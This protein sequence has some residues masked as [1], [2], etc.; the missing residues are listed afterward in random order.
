MS[1]SLCY[2]LHISSVTSA[3]QRRPLE[4]HVT[5]LE[6]LGWGNFTGAIFRVSLRRQKLPTTFHFPPCILFFFLTA[7]VE[8]SKVLRRRLVVLERLRGKLR[9]CECVHSHVY[10][11]N[12]SAPYSTSPPTRGHCFG[13]QTGAKSS[14]G[15]KRRS[16]S[17]QV[18]SACL[19]KCAFANLPTG[20]ATSHSRSAQDAATV[21]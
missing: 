16:I 5:A 12:C 19:S 20:F 9:K 7:G 17:F 2:L 13:S 21:P 10:F 3:N 14:G 6:N 1:K 15:S 18:K 8:G 4:E 11:Q